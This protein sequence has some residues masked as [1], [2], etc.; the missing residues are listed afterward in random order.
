M[1]VQFAIVA[2]IIALGSASVASGLRPSTAV[3]TAS[4]AAVG[5]VTVQPMIPA[6][7]PV[8]TV[9]AGTTVYRADC[10]SCHGSGGVGA[11]NGPRLA[12]PSNVV[13]TYSSQAQLEVYVAHSMP[14]TNPGSLS[15]KDAADVAAYVW[16][17]AGS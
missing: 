11:S 14:T 10:A 3:T 9:P 12:K 15:A 2:G 16:H 4:S 17:I 13:S 7:G 6:T 8:G 1:H 5:P